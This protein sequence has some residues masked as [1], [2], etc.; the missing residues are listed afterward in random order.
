MKGLNHYWRLVAT[1]LSFAVFGLGAVAITLT[2][3]PVIHLLSFN[4]RRAYRGC[5][6]VVHLSFRLFVQ[7]M[8]FLGILTYEIV[9]AEKLDDQDGNLIVANHPTLLDIVF[10][11]SLLPSALCVVKKSLW[12]N[13]FLAGLMWATGYIPGDD[14]AEL[15]SACVRSIERKNNLLI[16]PEATRSVAGQPIRLKRAA[17]S[18]IAESRKNFVPVIVTCHPP[19]LSKAEKWY[20]IPGR[21]M[22]FKV[23]VGDKINPQ[24][25]II[26]GEQL[27]Q[28]SRRVN[29]AIREVFLLGIEE[30]ERTG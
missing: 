28:T 22:H 3:F 25:L 21:K 27:S 30:H 12:R 1:G 18:I 23:T 19:S 10:L 9:G 5:Q 11:V 26:E 17:A 8:K 15:I 6:Y 2:A 13:P 29:E 7:M 24:P 20:D 14:P 16:F 4:R